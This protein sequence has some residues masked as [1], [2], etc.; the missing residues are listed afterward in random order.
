MPLTRI[1]VPVHLSPALTIALADAVHEGLVAT[2]NVPVNDRF[3]LISRFEPADMLID[4]SFPNVARTAAASIV[5]I[6]FLQGRSPGQKR[7]LYEH[8]VSM[9]V[10][11]GLVA[12]DLMIALT[13]NAAIDWSMGRG[14][15]YAEHTVSQLGWHEADMSGLVRR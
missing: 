8:I 13:E 6:T 14:E 12:D 7:A 15:A 1:A 3:Q 4:P 9:A 2:C 5:E 10:A 11:A